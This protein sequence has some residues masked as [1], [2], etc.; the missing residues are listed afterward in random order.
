M[1]RK[2]I[3]KSGPKTPEGKARSSQNALK[4]GL[5]SSQAL[6]QDEVAAELEEIRRQVFAAFNPQGY[7]EELYADRAVLAVW[8]LRRAVQ[9][10]TASPSP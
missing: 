4:H 7:F 2:I 5:F 3:R 10:E 9:V 1:R 8:R 6:L